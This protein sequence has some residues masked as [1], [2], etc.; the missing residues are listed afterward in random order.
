MWSIIGIYLVLVG[1]GCVFFESELLT[2]ILL[3]VFGLILIRIGKKK[4]IKVQEK[5]KI[6]A[7][8][9]RKRTPKQNDTLKVVGLCFM[10]G[11]P[12]HILLGEHWLMSEIGIFVMVLGYILYRK[13]E[14]YSR[15]ILL[16][17]EESTSVQSSQKNRKSSSQEW[18]DKY[19]KKLDEEVAISAKTHQENEKKRK[20]LISKAEML[21]SE[22]RWGPPYRVK[23]LQD[24]AA[25]LRREADKLSFPWWN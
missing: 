22:S 7:Q 16:Q 5:R 20:E 18:R 9:K 14:N 17:C 12:I 10:I 6:K 8:K 13:G 21:E 15:D 23:Q 19:K 2:G 24:E 4:E 25:A 3:L 11:P 1:V